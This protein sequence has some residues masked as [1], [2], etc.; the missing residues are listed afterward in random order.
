M[1]N[2][3]STQVAEINT[4]TVQWRNKRIA[5]MNLRFMREALK[6]EYRTLV[7]NSAKH[8]EN[9]RVEF[10]L[11]GKESQNSIE[12]LLKMTGGKV[13]EQAALELA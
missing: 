7:K 3:N 12:L 5:R 8:G 10:N 11:V 2:G 4:V 9:G 6:G 13:I 1:S